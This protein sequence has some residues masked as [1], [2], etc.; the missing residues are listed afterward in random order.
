MAS[1]SSLE[2]PSYRKRG[3]DGDQASSTRGEPNEGEPHEKEKEKE[4]T[5][6]KKKKAD[7]SEKIAA[8]VSRAPPAW[9][10]D[11]PWLPGKPE[12]EFEQ[13]GWSGIGRWLGPGAGARHRQWVNSLHSSRRV[14]RIAGR[15]ANDGARRTRSVAGVLALSR[16]WSNWAGESSTPELQECWERRG[17]PCSGSGRGRAGCSRLARPAARPREAL[18]CTMGWPTWRRA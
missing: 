12:D 13:S 9:A 18:R 15:C 7:A 17:P 8:I 16:W 3:D 5:K 1:G 4:K 2:P 11:L 6:K 10:A 14:L